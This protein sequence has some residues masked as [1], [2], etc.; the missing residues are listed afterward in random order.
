MRSRYIHAITGFVLFVAAS[1]AGADSMIIEF[2]ERPRAKRQETLAQFRRDIAGPR[3]QTHSAA[4]APAVRR[5]YKTVFFGAAVN[6]TST[7]VAAL[8]KLPYV[9]AIHPD[10]KVEAYSIGSANDAR[11]RVNA[12]S[13]PVQGHGMV[14]AVIDTGIDYNHPALGGGMG[15]S[16]KVLGGYDFVNDDPDPMDDNG[17]G[18]HVAGTVA[19]SSPH[20]IG[21]APHARLMAFKVLDRNG[22]GLVSDIIAG[23]EAAVDPD[24]DGDP[25]DHVDVINL[26]LGGP[27]TADDPSSRAVT[28]AIEAG[29]VVVVAA[30]NAGAVATI[31]SPG[32]APQAITVGATDDTGNVATFSSR[33]P[34]PKHLGF[35]P[36]IMA[37]GADILSTAIGG[38]VTLSSGTS[39][40]AP[41]IAGVAA[42]LLEM[43]PDWT[44]GRVKAALLTTTVATSGNPFERG[45]GRIDAAAAAESM[46]VLNDTGF[47]L[48]LRPEETGY[49]QATQKVL[50][51]NTSD[52]DDTLSMSAPDLPAGVSITIEPSELLIEAGKTREVTIRFATDDDSLPKPDDYLVGGDIVF[53]GEKSFVMPWSFVRAARVTVLYDGTISEIRG[54]DRSGQGRSLLR[55]GTGEAEMFVDAATRWDFLLT[56]IEG[57]RARILV[58]EDRRI[59]NDEIITFRADEAQHRIR[60][61]GRDDKGFLLRDLERSPLQQRTVT[62]RMLS[63]SNSG[64]T[65]I[66]NVDEILFSTISPAYSFVVT[67]SYIDMVNMRGVVAQYPTLHGVSESK[68]LSTGSPV[69][70]TIRWS[71]DRPEPLWVCN[72]GGVTRE[73]FNFSNGDC[74]VRSVTDVAE[75]S[76]VLTPAASTDAFAGLVLQRANVTTPAF[77]VWDGQIVASSDAVPGPVAYRIANGGEVL[78]G[79]GPVHPFAYH[80]TTA[81]FYPGL[82]GPQF[83]GSAGEASSEVVGTTWW[84]TLDRGGN[85]TGEGD[86][87]AASPAAGGPASTLIVTREGIRAA[88]RRGSGTLEV[89]FGFDERDHM[90]PTLTSMRVVD[91]TGRITDELSRGRSASLHFSVADFDYAKQQTTIPARPERTRVS[92]RAT[93]SDAWLPLSVMLAGSDH[94]SQS[95]LDHVPAGDIYRVDLAAVTSTASG[96]VDLRI[97]FVDAAGN[98]V[99]WTQSPALAVTEAPAASRRR[100]ARP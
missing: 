96:P 39:M 44:P 99:R 100:A 5:E 14:V 42:L 58:A 90:A 49:L 52:E 66:R 40:A 91:A 71:G 9:R 24:G 12:Q 86:I 56:S 37:P 55:Y 23:I 57:N 11:A 34:T 85:E 84:R 64:A 63:G 92:Y 6:A 95:D 65:Y 75:F 35:K 27:G 76:L 73:Y 97:E 48:G 41:H 78:L 17:H 7:D 28:R 74:L 62:V 43:N 94:G 79:S 4:P 53:T 69:T 45:T 2:V 72:A 32:T 93:G 15:R 36:E 46:W 51:T 18:T 33:G 3:I 29:V 77:R 68:L 21:V 10:G 38:G 88:G 20:L 70:A 26:S 25:S 30:G 80:G 19:A 22:D 59:E 81:G 60:F 1:T 89:V 67:E 61:D 50:I 98:E 47:S 87:V 31:G 82:P 83:A 16:Y 8:R 13:L 54:R